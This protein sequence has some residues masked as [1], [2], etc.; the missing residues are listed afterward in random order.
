MTYSRRLST[1]WANYNVPEVAAD[2]ET[3]VCCGREEGR[4]GG[5]GW[6]GISLYYPKHL[7]D[8]FEHRSA[9]LPAGR[10]VLCVCERVCM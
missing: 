1:S 4:D 3:V 8:F 6:G 7:Q 5:G 10:C 2:E 9:L